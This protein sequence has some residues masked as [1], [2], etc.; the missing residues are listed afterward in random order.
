MN[1]K[2]IEDNFYRVESSSTKGK[3]YKVNIKEETCTCPDYIFRARKRGGVCKHIRAVIEK[4]RKKNTSNFEKIKA[5]I[6]EHG[7]IDTAKLLKEFDEDLIDK[8]IQQGE[9]IEYKG[10]LRILE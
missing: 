5:A 9:V 3:F 10:K 1:I 2:N 6:K 7:E 4:F 8:L